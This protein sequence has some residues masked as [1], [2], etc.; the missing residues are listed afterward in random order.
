MKILIA[1]KYFTVIQAYHFNGR[2][3]RTYFMFWVF[4]IRPTVGNMKQAV[5][6]L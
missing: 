2:D 1:S 5:T 6:L 3:H 4:C